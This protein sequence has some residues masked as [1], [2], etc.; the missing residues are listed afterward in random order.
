M[1]ID[2]GLSPAAIADAVPG[3]TVATV[4]GNMQPNVPH[5]LDGG[6]QF[7]YGMQPG[8]Y[9]MQMGGAPGYITL[10]NAFAGLGLEE[11]V[12]TLFLTGAA[13]AATA[14]ASRAA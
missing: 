10:P 6:A 1:S 8:A 4:P 3:P 2:A 12:R 7:A 13:P 5:G 9:A 11:E 14:P